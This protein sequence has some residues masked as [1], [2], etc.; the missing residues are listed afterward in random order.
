[1]RTRLLRRTDKGSA[2]AAEML[3]EAGVAHVAVLRGGMEQWNRA[4]LPTKSRLAQER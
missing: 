2:R 1:M 3:R 4:R